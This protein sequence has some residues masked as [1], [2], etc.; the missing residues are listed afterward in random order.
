MRVSN[1]KSNTSKSSKVS[2]FEEE[3]IRHVQD[4]IHGTILAIDPS[5]GSANS[6]PGFAVFRAGQLVD[7]GIIRLPR[8]SDLSNRL[9]TLGET[10]RKEFLD[11][12]PHV[13][14]TERI[15]PIANG[16]FNARSMASL[17]KAIGVTISSFP[18]PTVEVSP[19][20]WRKNIPPEGYVKRDDHDA[21]LMGFTA[22]KLAHKLNGDESKM[23]V[24]PPEILKRITVGG[25][26]DV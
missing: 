23:S 22:I 21:I 17:Q 11:C 26:A 25:H 15:S 9:Y 2:M 5:S 19:I 20:Q 18:C 1:P 14:V 3:C 6:Q 13:L 16:A 8:G 4:L 7:C 24:L 12:A 10:L